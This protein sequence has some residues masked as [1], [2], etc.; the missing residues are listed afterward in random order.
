SY[1]VNGVSAVKEGVTNGNFTVTTLADLKIKN[2]GINVLQY[3]EFVDFDDI[4]TNTQNAWVYEEDSLPILFIDDISNPIANI[5]VSVYSWNNLS[6]KLNNVRLTSNIT[7]SIE[8]DDE[9]NPTKEKYYYVSNSSVPLTKT[10]ISQ[11]TTWTSYSG[12]EQI[13]PEGV[14]VI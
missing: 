2:N 1:Y 8:D 10:E 11:I 12:I 6:Y 9:L 14:Y 13:S 7:F 5:N 4:V 3:S